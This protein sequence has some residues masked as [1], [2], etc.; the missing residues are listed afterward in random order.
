VSEYS[1]SNPTG[2]YSS[3]NR[4]T[5]LATSGTN[6]EAA[7]K[8]GS[9]QLS[10]STDTSAGKKLGVFYNTNLKN[11]NWIPHVGSILNAT[12]LGQFNPYS[13]AT[14]ANNVEGLF[15]VTATTGS[16]SLASLDTTHG[17]SVVFTTGATAGNQGGFRQD[18]NRYT[19]R[20]FC[21]YIKFKFKFNETTNIRVFLGLLDSLSLVANS[22]DV[23]NTISGFGL[24]I[25][26]AS[27]NYRIFHNDAAGA[28]ISDDIGT[29]IDTNQHIIELLA[30]D[31]NSRWY[32]NFDDGTAS[33]FVTTEIPAQTTGLSF[34]ATYTTTTN[35]ARSWQLYPGVFVSIPR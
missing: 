29:A 30:D 32:W 6:I 4:K 2:S 13:G 16:I 8:Q 21:P 5:L 24:G 22:D 20:K 18:G 28:T 3:I 27:G 23:L 7:T 33:G 14:H 26:T 34:Q 19:M 10:F 1:S 25:S 17:R 35:V 9:G 11:D 15:L 31:N 12:D